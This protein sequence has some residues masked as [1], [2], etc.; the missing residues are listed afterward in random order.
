MAALTLEETQERYD[1]LVDL[2]KSR[3][4]LLVNIEIRDMRLW[5]DHV[6]NLLG[7]EADLPVP[8]R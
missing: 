2:V 5:V 1:A 4:V 6:A 8:I 3:S 7:V